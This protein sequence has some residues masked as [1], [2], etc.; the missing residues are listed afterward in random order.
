M[1]KCLLL[2]ILF[3][4]S[5][6][7]QVGVNTSNPQGVFHVDGAKDNPITGSPNSSQQANDFIITS[8]GNVGIGTTSPTTKLEI[9]SGT[10]GIS[11]LKFNNINSSSTPNS[12]TASLGIDGSGNVHVQSTAPILT[13]FKSFSINSNVA[14]N[15][16]ITIGSL[17]FRYATT[18]CSGSDSYIQIRSTSGANNIGIMHGAFQTAQNTTRL[19]NTAALVATPAFS[20]MSLL[21][22]NCIQDGHSQF[23]FYSYTDRTYYRVNVH[24][25]DGD[26]LGFGPLGYIFVEYQK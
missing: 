15:S 3:P 18:N 17:Q 16:L 9:T 7:C 5:A 23:S 21:P 1:K 8:A 14:S 6:F 20:N 26:S 12:N 4:I 2:T 22:M 10:N 11:G 19:V 13:S 25:A 24:I